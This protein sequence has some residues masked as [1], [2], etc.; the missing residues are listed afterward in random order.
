MLWTETPVSLNKT[1]FLSLYCYVLKLCRKQELQGQTR[2]QRQDDFKDNLN[3][4]QI[5]QMI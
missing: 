4:L 3:S 2:A 5:S 1:Q